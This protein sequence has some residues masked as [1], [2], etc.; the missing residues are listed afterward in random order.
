MFKEGNI[1]TFQHS[2]HTVSSQE[3]HTFCQFLVDLKVSDG[4][5]SNI[6]PCIDVQDGKIFR[7]KSHDSHGFLYRY[8]PLAICSVL[9]K[10]VCETLIEFSFFFRELCS[11]TLSLENLDLLQRTIVITLCKLEKIFPP[12]FDI[13]VHLPIHLVDEARIAGSVQYH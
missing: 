2:C 1:H 11:K 9:R 7:I 12:F 10:E 8:L 4:Y 3:K 6:S 5:S 13:M